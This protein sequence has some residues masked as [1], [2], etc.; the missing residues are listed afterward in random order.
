[1]GQRSFKVQVRLSLGKA[2]NEVSCLWWD[3]RMH[4][5][6]KSAAKS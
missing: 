6:K 4:I 1:V 2:T 3:W 5:K